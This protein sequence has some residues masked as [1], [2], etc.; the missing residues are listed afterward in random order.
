MAA[1]AV[2]WHQAIA[3]AEKM[4]KRLPDETE[5]EYAATACGKQRFPWGDTAPE[6]NWPLGPVGEPAHDRV[7]LHR[8]P[9]VFGLYSNVAEWTSSWAG[10]YPG[11]EQAEP[12][13]TLRVVRGAP[14][15][16]VTGQRDPSGIVRGPRERINVVGPAQL[17]GLGFRCARSARPR[18]TA[19]DFVSVLPR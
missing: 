11:L 5:Y 10:G 7:D 6:K 19:N 15:W 18:L 3:Y 12:D 16:V 9:P 1:T 4:G 13:S 17:P 8:Q 14:L 2:T